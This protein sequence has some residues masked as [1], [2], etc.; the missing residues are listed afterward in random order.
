MNSEKGMNDKMPKGGRAVWLAP[1]SSHA[2]GH[3]S[4]FLS[5]PLLPPSLDAALHAAG[6][7]ESSADGS[8]Y[9][10]EDLKDLFP[11]FFFHNRNGFKWLI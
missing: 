7:S 4:F 5:L 6:Y 8:E 10:D 3:D 11:K 2:V 9:S 1:L